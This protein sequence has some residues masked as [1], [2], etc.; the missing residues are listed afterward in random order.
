MN[1]KKAT[2]IVLPGWEGNKKTW[3]EFLVLS[4]DI[5]ETILIELPCFG[6]EPCPTEVW[7]VK[8]Y[9]D[10]VVKK[11]KQDNLDHVVLLG[12]SFGG[13][14]A[15]YIAANDMLDMS[16]LILSGA[17]AIRPKKTIKRVF[18]KIVSSFLKSFFYILG[19]KRLY[20]SLRPLIYKILGSNDYVD[21]QGI[22][23][24]IFKKVIRED[25]SE[26]LPNITYKTLIL[27]GEK[28]T[29][30]S[31]KTGKK[32]RDLI[33]GSEIKVYKNAGHGLHKQVTKELI[34]DIKNFIEICLH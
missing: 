5:F 25:L 12:H 32:I 34:E 30:V 8:E 20:T 22:K 26:I 17:A 3:N 19:L 6:K 18:L 21:S 15:S 23:T 14:V 16:G 33:K 24:E 29:Y 9:A 31:L 11:I 1:N 27:W 28:D 10:F 13:Q 2:L 4:R 7:G